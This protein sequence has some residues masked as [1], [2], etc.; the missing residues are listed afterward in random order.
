MGDG[1]DWEEVTDLRHKAVRD[2]RDVGGTASSA[3][4]IWGLGE[5]QTLVE[6]TEE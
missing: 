3:P 4:G 2:G 5:Q 6:N 1:R